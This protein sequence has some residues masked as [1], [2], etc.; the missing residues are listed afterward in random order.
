MGKYFGTDGFRGEANVKLTVD[1]AFK[2]GRYTLDVRYHLFPSAFRGILACQVEEDDLFAREVFLHRFGLFHGCLAWATP[3]CPEIDEH[4]FAPVRGRDG[5]E[6]FFR[7][8]IGNV[9]AVDGVAG[10]LFVLFDGLFDFVI[11]QDK[12]F[13][14]DRRYFT[15]LRNLF[16][17]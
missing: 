6:Q 5:I 2:V 17:A 9:H 11:H 1:H 14:K 16:V 15:G 8:N 10:F 12:C 3:S 7:R 13:L 4:D